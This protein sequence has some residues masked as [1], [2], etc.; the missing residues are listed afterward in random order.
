MESIDSGATTYAYN[1]LGERVRKT[2][3]S[4]TTLFVYGLNGEILGE[5]TG[6]G[7]PI[8]ETIWL[9]GRP[10]ATKQGSTVYYVHS[11]HLGTPRAVSNG[12]TVVWRWD[13]DP[14]G[15]AVA[16]EDPDGNLTSFTYNLRFPG[17]Y[18]DS[19]TGLHY[20]YFRTYDPSTGRYVES[21][22]IG[23]F[24]GLNSYG[25]ALQNPLAYVDLYGLDV[26]D[27]L[28]P[29]D[30]FPNE[31]VCRQVLRRSCD[32]AR[33]ACQ[34]ANCMGG[35][36]VCK[37]PCSVLAAECKVEADEFCE[38]QDFD[39][40]EKTP[41]APKRNYDAQGCY[42]DYRRTFW[43]KRRLEKICPGDKDYEGKQC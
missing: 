4:T 15:S 43:G 21:D 18:Y 17:Q 19:E 29:D 5:Y 9:D 14:F 26:F 11:D 37:Y 20:N 6:S 22:P 40:K 41:E 39:D 23:L 36:T 30:G 25:Y 32:A 38:G 27:D 42:Y 24:G 33:I 35:T 31:L 7:Q 16:D 2:T 8:Q 1:G 13:S 34:T 10:V 12:N 3:G 28:I